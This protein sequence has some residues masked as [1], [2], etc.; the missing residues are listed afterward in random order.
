MKVIPSP[1]LATLLVLALAIPSRAEPDTYAPGP[2]SVVQPGVP[3]GELITFDFSRSR[4]YPGTLRH[5]TVYVPR[6]YDPAKP[7]CVY[8]DQDGVQFNAPTVLDN[9]IARGEVPV[10]IGVF[11]TPGIVPA[12]D[13]ATA[14]GRFNR[15]FEYDGLGDGYARF[16][17]DEVLPE[18][19]SKATADGRPLHLSQ[20]GNDRAIAGSSSGAIAAF[21]AAWERPEA[22]S[23]VISAIGTYIGLR[24]AD[25]FPTLIRKYEP[26]PIRVF[27][28]DGS[29]DL[30]I[31]AGDWWM[32]N[33]TMERALTFSG[34][35][36]NH[37]WGDG[38][39]SG[40]QIT[41]VLPD[42]LRW[43]W[44]DWP[45]PV[46]R[47]QSR[48]GALKALL[49]PGEEWKRVGSGYGAVGQPAANAKGEVFFDQ[50]PDGKRFRVGLDGTVGEGESSG[51][52]YSGVHAFG[53]NGRLY[54]TTGSEIVIRSDGGKTT[55]IADGIFARDL[56]V[57]HNGTIYAVDPAGVPDGE[58]EVWMVGPAGT[59][60]VVDTGLNFPTGVTLSPDQSLL[61]VA[62]GLSH[63]IDI[64]QLKPDGTAAFRQRYYWLHSAD[65]SDNSGA[66]GMCCDV[67]GWLYVATELGIQ[68][69][70]Q[71]GRVNAILPVPSGRVTGLCF[72]GEHFDTL[73]AAC[74]DAVYARKLHATGAS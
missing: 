17:L 20:S 5:I 54:T 60:Q 48:N 12:R 66:G 8:V 57:A 41:A 37:A 19:E 2:D 34:Y 47:G 31:Y 52:N 30:N 32:A 11:V 35:E 38:S 3:Q 44:K 29:G 15:S 40:K 61:Y 14:L 46:S 24:G 43:V 73:Y 50:V 53:P 6:Q 33:Q 1:A 25:R 45:K 51:H 59:K 28:Q 62:E 9:L 7:A 67:A 72:G 27:L 36:V 4:V 26:K 42:A 21:N 13:P 71:A 65:S 74:G 23:R 56:V 58:G 10:M 16:I 70:D 18:V 22:F 63:W 39:H 64:Y 55:T 49:I 68:V 69:C